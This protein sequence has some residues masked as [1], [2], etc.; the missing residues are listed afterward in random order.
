MGE[1][2]ISCTITSCTHQLHILELGE[3]MSEYTSIVLKI[4]MIFVLLFGLVAI[5][6]TAYAID[7]EF[8]KC[9]GCHKIDEGKK[10]GM[11]PNLYGIFNSPAG[12][13]E[14]YRY[15]EWLKESG[16]V[17]TREA[18]HAWL[19]DRKTRE[20]YFGKDV[21]KTK[22]MWTGIKKEEQMKEILDYLESK[23]LVH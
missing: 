1:P 18:L 15:S 21:F 22:M 11:G 17:W 13:V 6:G 14:K 20:E 10:G 5:V 8:R 9:A 4:I 23:E 16:I 19:S 2:H 3:K 7:K 12:Q